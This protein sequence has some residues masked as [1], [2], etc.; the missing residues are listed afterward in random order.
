[1]AL[2]FVL[3]AVALLQPG[4]AGRGTGAASRTRFGRV[5]ASFLL[6]AGLVVAMPAQAA[7]LVSNVELC[8]RTSSDAISTDG[9]ELSQ[10]FTTGSAGATITSIEIYTLSTANSQSGIDV[11]L[12]SG[13]A[14][15]AAIATLT[16]PSTIH[17]GSSPHF[18]PHQILG[19][20]YC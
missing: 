17:A 15:S 11:T 13:S 9:Q 5:V 12:H 6:L 16:G 3:A 14:T 10:A 20:L 2:L 4:R 18:S 1:M 8:C 7:T 19:G